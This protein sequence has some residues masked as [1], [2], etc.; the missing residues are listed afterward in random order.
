MKR[1]GTKL[2]AANEAQQR[3]IARR[4]K[5]GL[6]LAGMLAA[7]ALGC[8]CEENPLRPTVVGD[9]PMSDAECAPAPKPS[10][11]RKNESRAHIR[12]KML[13]DDG[14]EKK[15]DRE[16]NG[17]NEDADAGRTA[18]SPVRSGSEPRK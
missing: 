18:G 15:P 8:G 6:P 10:G 14:A 16:H 5:L 9:V 4:I 7:A 17:K 13:L 12:G 11:N 3:E 1:K 2:S